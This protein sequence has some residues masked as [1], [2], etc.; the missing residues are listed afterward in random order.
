MGKFY[1]KRRKLSKKPRQ[2]KPKKRTRDQ[3][4]ERK[5]RQR[6]RYHAAGLSSK[7]VPLHLPFEL[8]QQAIGLS[9]EHQVLCGCR[10]CALV[11]SYREGRDD[12][13]CCGREGLE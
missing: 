9:R 6:A 3:E 10:Y 4:R 1:L 5:A 7:G 12:G 2:N 8:L 13:G 11:R